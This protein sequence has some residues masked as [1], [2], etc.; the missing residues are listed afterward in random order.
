M[1]LRTS[2]MLTVETF[3]KKIND[4]KK[5]FVLVKKHILTLEHTNKVWIFREFM[6]AYLVQSNFL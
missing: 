5:T 1:L 6:C 2:L 3:R 4:Y